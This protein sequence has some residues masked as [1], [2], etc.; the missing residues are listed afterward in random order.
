VTTPQIPFGR[1]L[2][3]AER[4]MSTLLR[5]HLAAYGT[6]PENWYAL[7]LIAADGPGAD[8]AVIS[9]T[10]AAGPT[11]D[12]DSTRALLARLAADGLVSGGATLDLTAAGQQVYERLRDY[13]ATPTSR[14]LGRLDAE[15]VATTVRTLQEI[16]RL[17]EA[18]LAATAQST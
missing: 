8:R 15:D 18:D 1:T 10:L 2:A 4:T 12:T 3:F 13:V 17:A 14:L 6:T 5:Q 11:L 16:T 7:Q 9:R